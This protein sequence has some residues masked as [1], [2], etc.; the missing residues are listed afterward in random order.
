[1]RMSILS[2]A[3]A[4]FIAASLAASAPAMAAPVKQAP[5]KEGSACHVTSGSNKGKTG[6][7][8]S[9]GDCAGSWGITECNN[10]GMNQDGSPTGKCA[11]GKALTVRAPLTV[12]PMGS[13]VLNRAF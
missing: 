1:M 8:N 10:N 13:V 6:A 5:S 9:D 7:Y 4:S 3:A 12:R 2:I 11:D